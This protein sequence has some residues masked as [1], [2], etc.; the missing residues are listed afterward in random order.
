MTRKTISV[1]KALAFANQT[2]AAPDTT[3]D[4]REAVCE[5]IESI[6]FES[7]QYAGFRYLEQE[8]H[9]DGTVKTL[10]SGSRRKY[11]MKDM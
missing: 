2:L 7:G 11:F 1:S 9:E 4:G 5:L 3:P 6:L 8:M 10:G